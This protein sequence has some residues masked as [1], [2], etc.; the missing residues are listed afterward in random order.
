MA[1]TL[2]RVRAERHGIDLGLHEPR[3]PDMPRMLS[4]KIELAPVDFIADFV[5]S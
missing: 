5:F 1:L 4:G 2:A 3:V